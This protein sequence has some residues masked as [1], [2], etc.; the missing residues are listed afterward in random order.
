M[1]AAIEEPPPYTPAALAEVKAYLR[2]SQEED[3][4]L[5]AG[6]IR[7]AGQTCERFIGRAL[8]VR[9]ATETVPIPREWR[10]L[11]LTPVAAITGVTGLPE[12]GEPFALPVEDYAIDIDGQGDG[13][14]RVT[15]GGQ[16]KRVRVAYQAGLGPDWNAV[17]EP[18]RQGIVR[19]VA[20]LFTHRDAIDDPG[21]PAAVTALWRP[22]R[23]MRLS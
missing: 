9:E 19:L 12:V 5:L 4:A 2:I 6:L 20:H 11:T 3:D 17:P 16:A 7:S 10:R 13:W 1:M 23:R 21:P 22:W 15:D 18:L 14:V 8:I